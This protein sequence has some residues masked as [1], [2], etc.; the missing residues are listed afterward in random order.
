LVLATHKLG[1]ITGR[2]TSYDV[3][4]HL[5]PQALLDALRA[6][7]EPPRLDGDLLELAEGRFPVDLRSHDPE[8]RVRLLDRDGVD[9]AVLSPAPTIEWEIC[10]ELGEAWHE[11]A[12]ELAA[13]SNGRF[14]ALSC[15]TCLDGFAGVCVSAS[16]LVAGLGSLPGE[17][18]RTGGVLFV[19]PGPPRA[20]PEWAPPWWCSVTDYT[21]QMQAAYFAWIADGAQR[22]PNLP[23]VFAILA[24]GAPFQLERLRS[25]DPESIPSRGDLYLDTASYGRRALELCLA[26]VGAE[27]LVYGSDVPVIESRPTLQA[28]SDL[29]AEVEGSVRR[30]NPTRLFG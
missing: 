27:R 24:G 12:H 18:E 3:H 17:L 1:S 26:T 11:G 25:R 23:V 15:G 6:R 8:E 9:V 22:H 29:G 5:W 30:D 4:Q 28:V 16:A 13:S 2:G 20:A 14:L 7:R 19:H 10:G 21:A